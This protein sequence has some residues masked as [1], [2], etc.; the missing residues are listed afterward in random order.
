M[1][2]AI[3]SLTTSP[4]TNFTPP[5]T[6]IRYFQLSLMEVN[7]VR[8]FV[9]ILRVI[10]IS[11]YSLASRT[12]IDAVELIVRKYLLLRWSFCVLEVTMYSLI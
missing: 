4:L 9:N 8:Q 1:Q 7:K 3:A 10:Y 2:I 5:L 11:L 6:L 12:R